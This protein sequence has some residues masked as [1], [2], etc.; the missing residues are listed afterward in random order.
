MMKII[1]FIVLLQACSWS[2][3]E[4]L[5]SSNKDE[6]ATPNLVKL[7]IDNKQ[8]EA[9]EVKETSKEEVLNKPVAVKK[10]IIPQVKKVET[11]SLV[12]PK[13]VQNSGIIYPP[14][15]PEDL[16]KLDSENSTYWKTFVPPFKD[17]EQLFLDV[18]YLGMTVGKVSI[19]YKGKKLI[20]N[21]EAYHFHSRFKS[22]PFYSAI[23]EL[24]DT[25]DTYV[26]VKDF[27]SLRY[28]LLQRESKQKVDDVQ[29]FD[30]AQLKTFA[31]YKMKRSDK[32]KEKKHEAQIPYYSLDA[33]SIL[34]FFRGLPLKTGDKYEIPVINKGKMI[35]ISAK[36]EA[37]EVIEVDDKDQKAIRV[38]MITKY[39]GETLKSGD[40]MLWFSDDSTKKLIK[41]KAKI[42]LGSITAEMVD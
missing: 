7:G 6:E 21:T 30:R 1:L 32:E 2:Q 25:V 40:M 12:K 28:T 42:K 16:K 13:I 23:Y 36:V 8:A 10:I 19:Y 38:H 34:Y 22:A 26:A 37:R 17:G 3:K 35:K 9:F 33:F 39:T 11:I 14:N 27:V 15:F 4:F 24:D 29:L 20:G 5:E 41:A 31:Y 18:D